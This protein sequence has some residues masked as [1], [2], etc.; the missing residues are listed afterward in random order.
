MQ[1]ETLRSFLNHYFYCMAPLFMKDFAF[2]EEVKFYPHRV[3][4]GDWLNA[5]VHLD[6]VDSNLKLVVTDCDVKASAGTSSVLSRNL[7][8]DK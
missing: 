6:S 2:S 8:T 1:S 3:H 7:I 5:A 4:V